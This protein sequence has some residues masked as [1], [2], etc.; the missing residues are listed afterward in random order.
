MGNCCGPFKRGKPAK[1]VNPNQQC[2][3]DCCGNLC[4]PDNCCESVDVYFDCGCGCDCEFNGYNFSGLRFRKKKKKKPKVPTFSRKTLSENGFTFA[5]ATVP[6]PSSSSSSSSS[7]QEWI[8]VEELYKTGQDEDCCCPPM[9]L[10]GGVYE[11][12]VGMPNEKIG[13]YYAEAGMGN[14]LG[15]G[16][17][18]MGYGV[19]YCGDEECNAV[20]CAEGFFNGLSGCVATYDNDGKLVR[21]VGWLCCP[22]G[23]TTNPNPC[24]VCQK[25]ILKSEFDPVRHIQRG[26]PYATKEECRAKC[27]GVCCYQTSVNLTTEGCCLYLGPEGIEAVGGG[28]I[29][30]SPPSPGVPGCETIVL[31]NGSANSTEV[32]DG[33]PVQIEIQ[34]GGGCKCCETQRDCN[35][36]SSPMWVQKSNKDRKTISLNKAELLKKVKFAAER[37][38]GRNR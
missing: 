14:C 34:T 1:A 9:C 24:Q 25:C 4:P 15:E 8:C 6:V 31:L 17:V 32:S 35:S 36:Q 26:G 12:S 33:D 3:A 13:A 29:A 18:G 38:R 28:K 30:A 16:P 22:E 5:E 11:D 37:V 19:S 27:C 20:E 10:T 21:R 2:F 23:S 7:S